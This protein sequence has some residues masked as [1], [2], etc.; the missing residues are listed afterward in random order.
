MA[1]DTKC[2]DLADAFLADEPTLQSE[3]KKRALAQTIQDA[4]ED[5][6]GWERDHAADGPLPTAAEMRGIFKE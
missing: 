1:Y 3:N 4:I 6:I 5:W 2:Y